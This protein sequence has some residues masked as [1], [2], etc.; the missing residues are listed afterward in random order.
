MDLQRKWGDAQVEVGDHLAIRFMGKA[1]RMKLFNLAVF[2]KNGQT[3]STD[4][5]VEEQP[6]RSF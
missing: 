5:V 4:F 1:G 3:V 6:E 2:H